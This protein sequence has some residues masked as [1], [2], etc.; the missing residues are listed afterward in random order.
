MAS[1][2]LNSAAS[3]CPTSRKAATG[4]P[5][6]PPVERPDS[7]YDRGG[8]Q[9]H[10]RRPGQAPTNDQHGRAHDHRRKAD[11][12]PRRGNACNDENDRRC[13]RRRLQQKLPTRE[14]ADPADRGRDANQ[15]CGQHIGNRG[16]QGYRSECR[17]Q[18]GSHRKLSCDRC[19]EGRGDPLRAKAPHRRTGHDPDR[20]ENRQLEAD[21]GRQFPRHQQAAGDRHT[22]SRPAGQRQPSGSGDEEDSSTHGGSHHRRLPPGHGSEDHQTGDPSSRSRPASERKRRENQPPQAEK[23][24]DVGSGHGHEVSEAGGSHRLHRN[25]GQRT[26][27]PDEESRDQCP[28]IVSFGVDGLEDAVPETIGDSKGRPARVPF[29]P[30]GVDRD[31][32]GDSPPSDS[33]RSRRECTADQHAISNADSGIRPASDC[34]GEIWE[35]PSRDLVGVDEDGDAVVARDR[36]THRG[37]GE[38]HRSRRDLVIGQGALPL[39]DQKSR[40]RPSG[41]PDH[42]RHGEPTPGRSSDDHRRDHDRPHDQQPEW[43]QHTDPHR[44]CNE[45]HTPIDPFGDLELHG[46]TTRSLSVANLDSPIPGTER[47]SSTSA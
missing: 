15:R 19:T 3:P 38:G 31:R 8:Q 41:N 17:D 26:R 24:S 27:I 42:H 21:I 16:E 32:S 45:E 39:D 22:Q 4:R 7:E 10:E 47:R 34:E 46:T 14:C 43:H 40:R 29:L 18:H 13:Q 36:I 5:S 28:G 20:G 44:R 6:S 23:Q 1:S 37:S 30:G 12:G 33:E 2:D 9:R 25:D 11:L 35:S